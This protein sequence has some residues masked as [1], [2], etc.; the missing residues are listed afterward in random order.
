MVAYNIF[1]SWA[2]MA[3]LTDEISSGGV[4]FEIWCAEKIREQGWDVSM[5]PI[6]GDQGVDLIA[7]RG[8]TSVAIQCKN[9]TG[10]IGNSAVQQIFAG[11]KHALA[12][13]ACVIGTGGFTKS[14]FEI[15]SITKVAL[16]NAENICE[17]SSKFGFNPIVKPKC[18]KVN[19][20]GTISISLNGMVAEV[21]GGLFRANFTKI[22]MGTTGYSEG[23]RKYLF[24]AISVDQKEFEIDA[25][26][27]DACRLVVFSSI[28]ALSEV[29]LDE[30]TR[31]IL[32]TH[33]YPN[34]EITSIIPMGGKLR[35]YLLWGEELLSEIQAAF[36]EILDAANYNNDRG[37]IEILHL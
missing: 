16:I 12:N 10:A 13:F 4:E 34:F 1:K 17:F 29:T 35:L 6:T 21:V 26:R 2:N 22:P 33:N 9:Y 25:S 30:Q 8:Q 36:G 31:T 27:I 18:C 14:A 32:A 5:T 19:D 28:I 24:D 20:I 23:F 7:R 11:Q 3:T 15:A 37:D